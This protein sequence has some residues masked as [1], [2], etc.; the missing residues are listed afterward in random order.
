[1]KVWNADNGGV[2]RTLTG[3]PDFLHALAVTPDGAFIAAAGEDG[4]VKIFVGQ[5]NQASRTI[6]VPE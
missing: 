5:A 2:Q 4:S 3:F 6:P 1:V